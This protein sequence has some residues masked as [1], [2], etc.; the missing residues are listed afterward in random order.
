M[1]AQGIPMDAKLLAA[2]RARDQADAEAATNQQIE[3]WPDM[4][5]AV[6]TFMAMGTQWKRGF[7]GEALG[8]DY[9]AIQPCAGMLDVVI[10]TRA[11]LDIQIM[12]S[13]ALKEMRKRKH[14]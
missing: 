11:F 8:L 4:A 10:D 12:E 3:I 14:G 13:A 2:V 5:P 9:S 1:A 6:L 7:F